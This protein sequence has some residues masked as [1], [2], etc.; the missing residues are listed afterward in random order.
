MLKF[1]CSVSGVLP[2]LYVVQ[3]CD[4]CVQAPSMDNSHQ[5]YFNCHHLLFTGAV[6]GLEEILLFDARRNKVDTTCEFA[7]TV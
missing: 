3:M 2:F 1:P 5:E 4:C 6:F 7:H